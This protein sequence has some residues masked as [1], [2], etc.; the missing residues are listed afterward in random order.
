M[1]GIVH[2]TAPF[3]VRNRDL[4]TTLRRAL[5]RPFGMPSPA[6]VV[7]F[8]SVF[9][10]ADPML[11]LTG[12]RC[13]PRRLLDAGFTFTHADLES[14]VTDLLDRRSAPVGAAR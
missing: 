9:L 2:A 10:G 14:A 4:M 12:R 13:V 8:G 5:H 6:P 1:S 3:P 11:V 7:R